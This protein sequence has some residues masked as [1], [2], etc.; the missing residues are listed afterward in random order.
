[1]H[2]SIKIVTTVLVWVCLGNMSTRADDVTA[3]PLPQAGGAA[4]QHDPSTVSTTLGFPGQH[5]PVAV[6]R[7]QRK[8]TPSITELSQILFNYNYYHNSQLYCMLR[9]HKKH[10]LYCK[11]LCP[12]TFLSIIMNINILVINICKKINN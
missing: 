10:Y 8:Q 6:H 2:S 3:S 7:L 4:S 11:L 5:H 12:K 9:R 1:M